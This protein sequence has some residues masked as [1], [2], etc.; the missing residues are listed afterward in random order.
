MERQALLCRYADRSRKYD[1]LKVGQVTSP[2]S[3]LVY[4]WF[5]SCSLG[6]MYILVLGRS[7]GGLVAVIVIVLILRQLFEASVLDHDGKGTLW[8]VGSA[9]VALAMGVFV[10]CML[11]EWL[12]LLQPEGGFTI[13]MYSWD[14]FSSDV[15]FD[16][17]G[18]VSVLLLIV[19]LLIC[20]LLSLITLFQIIVYI[21]ES[22]H[23]FIKPQIGVRLYEEPSSY[24]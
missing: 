4:W 22:I 23:G 19:V 10:V 16:I 9:T 14:Y 3:R 15:I 21:C 24:V 6:M 2:L 17:I 13:E 1:E 12:S 7:L 18:I 20:L 5:L 8:A 11:S